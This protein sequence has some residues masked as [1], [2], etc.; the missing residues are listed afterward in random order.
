MTLEGKV[1]YTI[2]ELDE[3]EVSDKEGMNKIINK[4]NSLYKK[5]KLD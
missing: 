3:S 5:D 4:L 2:L 1:L